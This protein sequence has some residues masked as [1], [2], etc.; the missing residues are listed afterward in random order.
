MSREEWYREIH[1]RMLN[2]DATASAEL[3]ESA[4]KPLVRNLRKRYPGRVESD[5]VADAVT[6]AL[7][8]YLRDPML[9]DRSKR[10]LF[11][12]L[13]M[14]ADGDLRNALAKRRR[15]LWKEAPLDE[16][17]LERVAGKGSEEGITPEERIDLATVREKIARRFTDP[18]DR[19]VV[20]LVLD[21]VRSTEAYAIVL[22]LR[23]LR[24]IVQRK[25]VKRHKDRIK[26][27]LKTLR[28]EIH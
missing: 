28:E 24:E 25:E 2:G 7:M 26:K 21:G 10:G 17:E 13:L 1:E 27:R 6:D 9:F 11:G 18:I 15:R 23:G 22:G 16:V 8:G 14:A 20:E 19:Q 4:L 5:M 3:V 12:F